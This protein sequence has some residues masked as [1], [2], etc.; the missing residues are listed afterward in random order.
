MI[1]LAKGRNAK[2]FLRNSEFH[3]FV[4]Q[5]TIDKHSVANVSILKVRDCEPK[6]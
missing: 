4:T 1:E 5:N 2:H 3:E 6:L